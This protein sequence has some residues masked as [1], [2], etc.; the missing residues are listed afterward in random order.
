MTYT[1][2]IIGSQD[3]AGQNDVYQ[4][5]ITVTTDIEDFR[6]CCG[7][8]VFTQYGI[9]KTGYDIYIDGKQVEGK[10]FTFSYRCYTKA[11]N[12]DK[13]PTF[14]GSTTYNTYRA[15]IQTQYG[16]SIAGVANPISDNPLAPHVVYTGTNFSDVSNNTAP[17]A[18]EYF[19][20]FI[21]GEGSFTANIPANGQVLTFT[22]QATGKI[23]SM[24]ITKDMTVDLRGN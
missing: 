18:R 1:W 16:D 15:A 22:S 13:V 8:W 2:R 14:F 7:I 23:T 24:L 4:V 9:S 3:N 17:K 11:G 5:D 6:L 10:S 21:H 20:T 19:D 12:Y